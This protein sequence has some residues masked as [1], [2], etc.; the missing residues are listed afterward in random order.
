MATSAPAGAVWTPQLVEDLIARQFLHGQDVSA[1]RPPAPLA[2]RNVNQQQGASSAGGGKGGAASAIVPFS[3]ATKQ[4]MKFFNQ[5]MGPAP[6]AAAH[7]TNQNI[8]PPSSPAYGNSSSATAAASA[9]SPS[10]QQQQQMNATASPRFAATSAATSPQMRTQQQQGM[11]PT[12]AAG[13]A[14]I[15]SSSSVPPSPSSHHQLQQLQQ[16]Q[17]QLNTHHQQQQQ[18]Q[19]AT[20]TLAAMGGLQQQPQQQQ[21]APAAAVPGAAPALVRQTDC[22]ASC[23]ILAH[24]KVQFPPHIPSNSQLMARPDP[25]DPKKSLCPSATLM[26]QR[27]AAQQHV[28]ADL[29]FAQPRDEFPL[30]RIFAAYPDALKV[31]A[32]ARGESGDWRSDTFSRDEEA[33]Y[34]RDMGYAAIGPYQ[35]RSNNFGGV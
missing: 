33:K 9:L 25:N 11:F 14:P 17:Q 18:Q 12:S 5:N 34:K 20:N 35:A 30:S 22:V 6:G 10:R 27:I 13:V 8:P 4:Y 31:I 32:N 28:D 21:R 7:T 29:I 1:M 15:A 19:H 3:D 16:I 26:M 23:K 2:A 24:T